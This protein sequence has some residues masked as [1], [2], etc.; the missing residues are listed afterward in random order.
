M[1]KVSDR[2]WIWGHPEG[3]HEKWPGIKKPSRMTP[4]E[5]A[6][7][8]GVPNLIMVRWEGKPRPPLDPYAISFR[9]L[10]QVVWSIVGAAGVARRDEVKQVIDLSKR[11]PNITGAM[12][13]DF[14]T[15]PPPK[16]KDYTPEEI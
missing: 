9:P 11:F 5:G 8:L 2:L 10:K 4:A 15:M 12:M 3:S 7:Y 16:D 14:F 13:D 1:T 6:Y